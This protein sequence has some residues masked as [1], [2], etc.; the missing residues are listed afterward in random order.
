[1]ENVK[2]NFLV[3]GAARAGTT[4]LYYWLKQHPEVFMPDVKEPSYFVHDYGVS[5][6]ALYLSLFEPG[7]GKKARGEASAAYLYC[8]E[9]PAWIKSILGNIKIIIILRN[10]VQRAFSLY[11]WMVKEGYED[12]R[13]FE[14]A[15]SREPKRMQS[16]EFQE[17]CPQFFPDYLY[18][19]TGLYFQQIKRYYDIF[20]ENNVRVYLFDDLV[21]DPRA[22][23]RDIY[24]F[25]GVD[26]SFV[27]N[28]KAYNPGI[29]P[30]SVLFQYWLR[31]KARHSLILRFL[32]SAYSW[33]I[34]TM[35]MR[36][37]LRIGTRPKMNLATLRTLQERYG[38]N[39]INLMQLLDRDVSHWIEDES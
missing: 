15:L 28:L 30:R 25:L 32:P 36:L 6:W 2:P 7:R 11:V 29:K 33:R 1:M 13:T 21:N 31:T 14:D 5:D 22:L 39:I 9:S 3:V 20:G 12:A 24:D 19:T 18:Y 35:L 23:I 38:P 17:N 4:S 10:P 34:Q 27:P 26:S 8:K 16:Y 37:N